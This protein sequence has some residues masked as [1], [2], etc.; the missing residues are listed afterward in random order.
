MKKFYSAVIKTNGDCVPGALITVYIAGSSNKAAIYSNEGGTAKSNPFTADNQ[1]R[2]EFYAA[3][4]D[5]DI[6]V[7]GS[8]IATYKLTDITIVDTKK[9][10][11]MAHDGT[12]QVTGPS[13]AVNERIVIFDGTTGKLVK[14]SGKKIADL[15]AVPANSVQG[16]ILIRD[17][18]GWTRLPAGTAGQYLET[19]GAGNNPV[20][21]TPTGGEDLIADPANSTQGDILIRD[22]NGWTRLP[23]GNSGQFL[24]TQGANKNPVWDNPEITG[25]VFGPTTAGDGRIAV[26]DGDGKHIKDGGKTIQELLA[27]CGGTG[28]D[29]DSQVLS[30]LGL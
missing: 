20:W 8:E 15:I 5:Y 9:V 24:K 10:A 6:E 11:Q 22:A 1:G 23:A 14:D 3:D 17:A 18:S 27:G 13:S 4:G 25:D 12:V 2:F 26:F 30:F 19:Q 21:S 29:E 16:D 28:T 7:R